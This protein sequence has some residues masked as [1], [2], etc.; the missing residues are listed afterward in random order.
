MA[1]YKYFKSSKASKTLATEQN[2]LSKRENES[3]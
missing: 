3:D 1:L 2:N